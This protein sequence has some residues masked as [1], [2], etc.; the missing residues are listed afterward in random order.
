MSEDSYVLKFGPDAE[1]VVPAGPHM[2]TNFLL[3]HIAN[4]LFNIERALLKL[5]ELAERR[6]PPWPDPWGN[7]R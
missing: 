5:I 2:D 4:N 1:V 7:R 6:D 3:T